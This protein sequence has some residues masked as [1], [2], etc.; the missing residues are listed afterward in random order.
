[1][2]APLLTNVVQR[3]CCAVT[4]REASLA[5]DRPLVISRRPIGAVHNLV[6]YFSVLDGGAHP[7]FLA[8]LLAQPP[9]PNQ[10][11]FDGVGGIGAAD[12]PRPYPSDDGVLCSSGRRDLRVK[13]ADAPLGFVANPA[14]VF[15]DVSGQA[16][17]PN[18]LCSFFRGAWINRRTRE[19]FRRYFDESLVDE[20][21]KRVEI[22][23]VG[24]QAQSLSL[25]R[26][27]STSGKG[28]E[29]GGKLALVALADFFAGLVEELGV[30]AVLPLYEPFHELVEPGAFGILCLGGGKLLGPRRWI[31][32]KLGEEDGACRREWT[33][34]PI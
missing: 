18:P 30:I 21:C 16:L 1:M 6:A 25:E 32:H 19:E 7:G 31:V 9:R 12:R 2:R 24:F 14:A 10:W 34:C 4:N 23:G 29:D 28:I 13:V 11:R 15:A 17:G 33:T 20:H 5:P 3:D 8:F 22:A 27:R 26:D